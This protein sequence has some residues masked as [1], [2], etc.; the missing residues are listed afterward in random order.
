VINLR[1]DANPAERGWV[2]SLGMTDVLIPQNAAMV[3][4]GK[5]LEFLGQ[6]ETAPKPAFV[7]CRLGRDRT[8]LCVAVYRIVAQGW[9]RDRAI[10]ELYAHG[11][12]WPFFPGIV[13]YVR[14]FDTGGYRATDLLAGGG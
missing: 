5:L 2:E 6:M 14:G 11:Y 10:R 9:D 13:R 4:P 3:E 7:H 12:N 1:D 8:G